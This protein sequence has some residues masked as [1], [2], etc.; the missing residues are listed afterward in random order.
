MKKF[1]LLATILSFLSRIEAQSVSQLFDI[2]QGSESSF[3]S[4]LINY[5]ESAFFSAR[6]N[7]SNYEIWI[8]NGNA[9][10][11]HL[12]Y[13]INSDSLVGSI[14]SNF[15][16]FNNR[17]FFVANDGIHGFELWKTDGTAEGTELVIDLLPGEYS[18]YP[19]ELTVWNNAL[20][21]RAFTE[22]YGSELWKTNGD[23]AST[24]LVADMAEGS[25]SF[26]PQHLFAGQ[27]G[28]YFCRSNNQGVYF[29]DGT[30]EGTFALA[31]NVI[32]GQL[33]QPYFT[34]YGSD[35]YFRGKDPIGP[36]A[37]GNQLWRIR[38]YDVTRVTAIQS[39]YID[40]NPTNLTTANNL[41]FFMGSD[42][43]HGREV[44]AF[45]GQNAFLVRDIAVGLPDALVTPFFTS[46]EDRL[47]FAAFQEESGIELWVSD[48]T[49]QGTQQ[50][51]DICP[52]PFGSFPISPKHLD[53]KLFFS[54][55]NGMGEQIWKL[56]H[57]GIPATIFSNV[58]E[59]TANSAEMTSIN[60]LYLFTGSSEACGTELWVL[61][62][63]ELT[64]H[65][66]SQ[67]LSEVKLWP[68]PADDYIEID[69][70]Q[71]SGTIYE[72]SLQDLSGKTMFK[73]S[74]RDQRI[75]PLQTLQ[76]DPGEYLIKI[77]NQRYSN[78]QRVIIK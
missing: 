26:Y 27:N 30:S 23:A 15:K 56:T 52:G 22:N 35:I 77:E 42:A 18:S 34:Q 28:L 46:F 54:A 2:F 31:L 65:F 69:F 33:D 57:P 70:P 41:L 11:T 74:F 64:E 12:L 17:L 6:N 44:W 76:I 73:C 60:G 72:F 8:S 75:F 5:N 61:N 48:G 58:Y 38:G 51:Q 62:E 39:K 37:A 55:D 20:Y 29:S 9:N 19:A 71:K 25:L 1:L 47:V 63:A 49:V 10:G 16:V 14:P 53:N 45:D 24:Q 59:A 32:A 67:E 13:E 7:E 66:K 4:E 36:S 43:T 50:L 3:P 78:S 40:L 21:F 68:N